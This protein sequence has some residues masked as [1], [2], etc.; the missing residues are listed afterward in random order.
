VDA[1][2]VVAV[3]VVRAVAG[4]GEEGF[5]GEERGLAGG[6]LEG[7]GWGVGEGGFLAV[8]EE[9]GVAVD[10][11][12][13]E[14]RG[15]LV[16]CGCEEGG[17]T[18]NIPV[19]SGNSV[20]CADGG[21]NLEKQGEDDVPRVP[22]SVVLDHVPYPILERADVSEIRDKRPCKEVRGAGVC[23][24]RGEAEGIIV[25]LPFPKPHWNLCVAVETDCVWV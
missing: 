20:G 24:G 6:V 22:L 11:S 25:G 15:W 14:G 9:D 13:R 7:P 23:V 5:V 8:A 17:D 10:V 3:K 2:V 21:A 4:L 1:V 19:W 18:Q 12:G 16:R